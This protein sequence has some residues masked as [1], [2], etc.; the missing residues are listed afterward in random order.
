MA[1]NTGIQVFISYSHDSGEHIARVRDLADD[2][3]QGFFVLFDQYEVEPREGW[4]RWSRKCMARANFILAICTETY[5]RRVDGEE[6]PGVGLGATFESGLILSEIYHSQGGNTKIIPVVFSQDDRR[7]VP[8]FLSPWTIFDAGQTTGRTG[9]HGLKERLHGRPPAVRPMP[10]T[11]PVP[12]PDDEPLEADEILA[13]RPIQLV[14][15]SGYLRPLG[16]ASA[17]ALFEG[18]DFRIEARGIEAHLV[19]PYGMGP[20]RMNQSLKIAV[21]LSGSYLGRGP[22]HVAG[23]SFPSLAYGNRITLL[24]SA[25]TLD[26]GVVERGVRQPFYL[27]AFLKGYLR[28]AVLPDPREPSLQVQL[29]GE[30]LVTVI[31]RAYQQPSGSIIEVAS[32]EYSFTAP[33]H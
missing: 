4:P 10:E 9:R 24:S 22:A 26:P 1:T 6:P 3:S 19:G 20:L 15:N 29:Y 2:L 27:S 13:A 14:V 18:T 31:F 12:P 16:A 28:S 17:E 23:R 5:L 25:I 32:T 30:G 33:T 21:N 11:R 7:F 8:D